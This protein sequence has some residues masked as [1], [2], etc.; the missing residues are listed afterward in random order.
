MRADRMPPPDG[1]DPPGPDRRRPH[2]QGRRSPGRLS[3]PGP[4]DGPE[5]GGQQRAGRRGGRGAAPSPFLAR[6]T[7]LNLHRT[8]LTDAGLATLARAPLVARLRS[9]DLSW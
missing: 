9:L 6:L 2:G 7:Y 5:P 3:P 4:A 8:G 1:P